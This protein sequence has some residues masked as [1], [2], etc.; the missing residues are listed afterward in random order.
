MKKIFYFLKPYTREFFIFLFVICILYGL[1][2]VFHPIFLKLIFDEATI[3][4]RTK[5]FFILIF[6]YLIFGLFINLTS[7]LTE[8]WG[9]ALNNRILSKI[10][11]K[12]MISYYKKDYGL[13]LQKGDGY[14]IGRVYK[15]IVEAFPPFIQRVKDVATNLTRMI[16]FLFVLFYISWQ[17]TITVFFLIP[18]VVYFST[19]LSKKI[20]LTT[21]SEREKESDFLNILSKNISSYKIVNSLGILD[22]ILKITTFYLLK[23]LDLLYRNFKLIIMYRT[24]SYIIMNISDAVSLFVGALFLLK[25]RLTFGGYLAFITAFWRAVTAISEFLAPFAELKRYFTIVERIYEFE[26]EEKILYFEKGENV[27]LENVCFSYDEKEV[28]NNFSLEIKKGEKILITGPNGSG[29]TTIANIISGLLKPSKGKV[30]LPERIS[31][32]TLPFEFPLLKLKEFPVKRELLNKFGL[33]EFLEK[34]PDELSAGQ[35]QK[36]AISLTLSKDADLYIFDEPLTN[37]DKESTPV[38]MKEILEETK[39]KTL[40]VIMHKGEEF[41]NHFN[42]IIDLG[43]IGKVC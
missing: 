41:Y 21:L 9:K 42:R 6:V 3:T 19:L 40:V 2:A 27:V 34:N 38:V 17:A 26:K 35:K 4:K 10:I 8:L 32:L 25:G 12:M 14:F 11:E 30:I 43:E 16:S 36:F 13:I 20:Q 33:I 18:F 23:Y 29:K 24:G 15:D 28:L 7:Y 37:L 22:K 39:N 5:I 1:E 31:S